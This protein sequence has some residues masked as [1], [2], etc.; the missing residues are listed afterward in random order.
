MSKK[1]LPLTEELLKQAA[2]HNP[3][4]SKEDYIKEEKA[5]EALDVREKERTETIHL[6]KQIKNLLLMIYEKS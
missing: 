2:P 6:L 4:K 3:Q 5:Y 1:S